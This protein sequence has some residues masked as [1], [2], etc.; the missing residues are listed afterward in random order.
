MDLNVIG[1]QKTHT[2][3]PITS[4]LYIPTIAD[5]V[6]I[7]LLKLQIHRV[8][9]FIQMKKKQHFLANHCTYLPEKTRRQ[10]ERVTRHSMKRPT[11]KSDS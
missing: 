3:P 4:F 11:N 1:K 2:V 8:I 10:V 7:G 9:W 5:N 6:A